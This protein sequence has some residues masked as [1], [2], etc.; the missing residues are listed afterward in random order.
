[1]LMSAQFIWRDL[2][3]S[4]ARCGVTISSIF[5]NFSAT[6]FMLNIENEQVQNHSCSGTSSVHMDEIYLSKTGYPVLKNGQPAS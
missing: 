3:H 5:W 2:R 4:S 1:M 6:K